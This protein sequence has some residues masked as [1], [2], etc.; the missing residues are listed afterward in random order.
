MAIHPQSQKLRSLKAELN[1]LRTSQIL[2]ERKLN[3]Q[4]KSERRARTRTLIQIGSL[5]N[6]IGLTELCHIVEGEDLQL[7]P[8]AHDK[9]ATLLGM[10]VT[11][12]EQMPPTLSSE[13]EH[14]FKQKGIR[15]FKMYSYQTIAKRNRNDLPS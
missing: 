15:A 3:Q 4:Q 2:L 14:A 12:L 13:Q 5:V 7:D 6:M 8:I 10:L 11:L 1:R 9:A